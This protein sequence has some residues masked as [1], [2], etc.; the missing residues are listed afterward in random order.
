MSVYGSFQYDEKYQIWNQL[1][2]FWEGMR[3]PWVILEDFNALLYSIDKNGGKGIGSFNDVAFRGY[4]DYMDG[5]KIDFIGN[6]FT[7]DNGKIGHSMVMEQ[8]G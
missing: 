3:D 8:L 2:R 6:S 1:F 7:W 4:M 5:I